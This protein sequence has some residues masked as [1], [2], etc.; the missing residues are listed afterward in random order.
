MQGLVNVK[1]ASTGHIKKAYHIMQAHAGVLAVRKTLVVEESDE[2]FSAW[3]ID[4]RG[5]C[6]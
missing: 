2:L 6:D 3:L 4:P 5:W 1:S